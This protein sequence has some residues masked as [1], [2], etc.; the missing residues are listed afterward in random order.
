MTAENWVWIIWLV[1]AIGGGIGF[2]KNEWRGFYVGVMLMLALLAYIASGR[3]GPV[4]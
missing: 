4:Q 3:H 1:V 2:W